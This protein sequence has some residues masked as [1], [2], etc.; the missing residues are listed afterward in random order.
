MTEQTE[1][2]RSGQRLLLIGILGMLVSYVLVFYVIVPIALGQLPGGLKEDPLLFQIARCVF[3]PA[4]ILSVIGICYI[5]Q[6]LRFRLVSCIGLSLLLL[7]PLI[8]LISLLIINSKAT[9]HLRAA[10]YKVRLFG[11]NKNQHITNTIL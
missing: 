6:G 10:G 1:S 2:I 4:L 8:S 11:A 3:F 7:V 9:D 5:S